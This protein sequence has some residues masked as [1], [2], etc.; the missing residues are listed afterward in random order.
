MKVRGT[1]ECQSCGE[2]WSYYDTGS[3]ECP[4]C[5]S[6]RSVGVDDERKLHT[7]TD[8][9]L[10]LTEVREAVD[11]RPL[12][13]V[14][15]RAVEVTRSFTRGHGF[16]DGGR[17]QP[18]SDTY[19]AAAELRSVADAVGRATRVDDEEEYYFLSLLRGADDGNRPNPAAVPESLRDSRGLAYAT[20]VESYRD[21]LRTY[22]EEYP[23][24][25]AADTL[26][27]LRGHVKR[28]R[29]LDGDVPLEESESL[30]AVAREVGR[31]LVDGDETA[32]ARAAERLDGL[33]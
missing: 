27:R 12:R 18:L 20:A 7:A 30:V 23:D 8:A 11:E 3:V 17:L 32:L 19:L 2:R 9:R 14:A 1:R 5:G 31:Y 4:A 26:G 16:I 21:E 6:L 24:T 28:A 22:L 33:E 25:A 29:A 10:D 15:E 13:E